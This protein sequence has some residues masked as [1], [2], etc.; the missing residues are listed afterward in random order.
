MTPGQT[1]IVA[2]S[3]AHPGD[4]ASFNI[5]GTMDALSTG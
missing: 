2:W 1:L 5:I 4:T 3:G